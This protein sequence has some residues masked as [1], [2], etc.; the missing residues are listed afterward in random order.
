L[1]QTV[2]VAPKN[3]DVHRIMINHTRTF[4]TS[5]KIMN[6]LITIDEQLVVVKK[7]TS[8]EQAASGEKGDVSFN[9]VAADTAAA[10]PEIAHSHSG[11]GFSASSE[12]T[13]T[14]V[15]NPSS[16]LTHA[17]IVLEAP[18]QLCVSVTAHP[19]FEA[20]APVTQQRPSTSPGGTKVGTADS[21]AGTS[22][23]TVK[24]TL[25]EQTQCSG[26]ATDSSQQCTA[27]SDRSKA[28]TADS[29][30]PTS[31]DTQQHVATSRFPEQGTVEN[32]TKAPLMLQ[33]FGPLARDLV[34]AI[35]S[36]AFVLLGALLSV[37]VIYWQDKDLATVAAEFEKRQ[38]NAIKTRIL[39]RAL[40]ANP[41][42]TEG[43]LGAVP[44]KRD[45]VVRMLQACPVKPIVVIAPKVGGT[46]HL[47][48]QLE[49]EY[50]VKP[51]V[52]ELL[53]TPARFFAL[54]CRGTGRQLPCSPG[55]RPH[56][57]Y[58]WMLA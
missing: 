4:T 32:G 30:A 1:L 41:E 51:L 6:P 36:G 48:A 8:Q 31:A 13:K 7:P 53:L 50:P 12:S 46:F 42:S 5:D 34:I 37:F 2:F 22:S 20:A 17:E 16:A 52:I 43:L 33:R 56:A 29:E 18:N 58:T 54:A 28:G 27:P 57:P 44:I 39:A 15:E 40:S 11:T 10:A 35:I 25:P 45:D 3:L 24:N 47:C 14:A 9:S 49:D 26:E 23:D 21:A 19:K 55:R 38:V